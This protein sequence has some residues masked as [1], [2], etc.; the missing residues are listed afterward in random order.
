MGTISALRV[1]YSPVAA[2]SPALPGPRIAGSSEVCV[3]PTP[4]MLSAV[5]LT[6]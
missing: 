1:K 2:L 5:V 6:L 3:V 4:S